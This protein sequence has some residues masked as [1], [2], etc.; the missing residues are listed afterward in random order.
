[1]QFPKVHI[2]SIFLIVFIGIELVGLHA[3]SHEW[4]E[5]HE[6]CEICE[7]LITKND[8]PEISGYTPQIEFPFFFQKQDAHMSHYVQPNKDTK[9]YIHIFSRPPPAIN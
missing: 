3:F 4:D 9:G 8:A 5:M 7:Y 6:D 1:M 2:A